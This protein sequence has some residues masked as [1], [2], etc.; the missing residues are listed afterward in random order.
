MSNVQ[1]M[2]W[3]A[4]IPTVMWILTLAVDKA[5]CVALKYACVD[6]ACRT[7]LSPER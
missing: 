7:V 4:S 1:I 5:N 3:P 2:E 6:P